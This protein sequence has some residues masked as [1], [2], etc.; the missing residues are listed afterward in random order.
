[1]LTTEGDYHDFYI[2]DNLCNRYDTEGKGYIDHQDFLYKLGGAQ[3]APSDTAGTSK[4]IMQDSY[5]YLDEHHQMQQARQE[6]ITLNQANRVVKMT[7]DQLHQ[8]LKDAIREQYPDMYIAFRKYDTAKK[9][10]LSLQQI[11]QVLTD[12]KIFIDDE[13]FSELID[14]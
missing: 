8:K 2:S 14:R 7:T 1:M 6:K 11:Q 12:L 13:Q 10:S 3:F 5:Q 9:G 4:R